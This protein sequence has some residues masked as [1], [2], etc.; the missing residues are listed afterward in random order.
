MTTYDEITDIEKLKAAYADVDPTKAP[1]DDGVTHAQYGRSL[2][3]NL[4]DLQQRLLDGSYQMKPVKRLDRTKPDGSTR[5]IALVA[6]EDK[7]VQRA[8]LSTLAPKL[9][10]DFFPWSAA[11]TGL[12]TRHASDLALVQLARLRPHHVVMIDIRDFFGSLDHERLLDL[13]R[14][15]IGDE[16]VERLVRAFLGTTVAGEEGAQARTRGIEQ[17]M[18]IAMLLA[19]LYLHEALDRWVEEEHGGD[20][21]G[22]AP[23]RYLDDVYFALHDDNTQPGWL[24]SALTKRLAQWG[25]EVSAAKTRAV[26]FGPAHARTIG[27]APGARAVETFEFV[28]SVF[29]H[30]LLPSGKWAPFRDPKR[31][32]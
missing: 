3:Q 31:D 13:V 6:L 19:N 23:V 25:L 20:A 12:G 27:L 7:V 22:L 15:R 10:A 9:E 16:R 14:A 29:S 8:A 2:D 32:E 1:G 11:R 26:P 21:G 17:G 5:P 24:V 18:P 28:G 4:R 30:G